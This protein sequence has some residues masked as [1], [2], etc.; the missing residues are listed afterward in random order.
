MAKLQF[1]DTGSCP[2]MYPAQEG[3]KFGL[4][5][6]NFI[7]DVTNGILSAPS[8]INGITF[9]GVTEIGNNILN[10]SFYKKNISGIVSFP[11]LIE[12]D[13]YAAEYAFAENQITSVDLSSLTTVGVSSLA[14]AFQHNQITSV[15]LSSLTS[16]SNNGLYYAF[17]R[18]S[19]TTVDLSALTTIGP[20]GL[21]CTFKYN[22]ITSVNLSSLESV[23]YEGFY[24][25]FSGN[26]LSTVSF[27]SLVS[28]KGHGFYSAFE[29][30]QDNG[31]TTLVSVSFPAL[32]SNS[33]ES[34]D[35]TAFDNMLNGNEDVTVHF[36]S[37][38][39]SVIGNWT[40]VQNGFCGTN[41]TVLFDLP[42]TS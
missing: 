18:N 15:D 27:P 36:P 22:Q 16:I 6:D 3:G 2:A 11:N 38:L 20:W 13:N 19:I 42:A 4:T 17:E 32:T 10:Y 23:W 28:I 25:A 35:N 8:P 12:T 5:V 29:W 41:T 1:G 40:S 30:N 24:G 26:K 34:N 39:Q 9:T 14:N 7:G 37:N 21:Q 33:F 31:Q